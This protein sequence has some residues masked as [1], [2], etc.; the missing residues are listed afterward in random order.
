[1]V[2]GEPGRKRRSGQR[3]ADAAEVLAEG[4]EEDR[5]AHRL[6]APAGALGL[7]H[8]GLGLEDLV[9]ERILERLQVNRLLPSDSRSE[10]P[11]NPYWLWLR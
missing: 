7:D 8:V 9:V 5:A 2:P 10:P 4:R 11:L 6:G 1:M 3:Q